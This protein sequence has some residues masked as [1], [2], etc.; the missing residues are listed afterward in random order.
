MTV[1]MPIA[2]ADLVARKSLGSRHLPGARAVGQCHA[3]TCLGREL[4]H[5]SVPD[6]SA[7]GQ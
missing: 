4:K 2:T 5:H 6:H 7:Y 1:A 3:P